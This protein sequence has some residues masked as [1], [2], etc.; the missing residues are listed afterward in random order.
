MILLG[1][2]PEGAAEEESGPSSGAA[3]GTVG[4]EKHEAIVNDLK[5]QLKKSQEA[6][7]EL[8]LLLDMYKTAP[9]E[10]RDKVELMAAEKR[11]KADLADLKAQLAK[12]QVG[13]SSNMF[14]KTQCI[15]LNFM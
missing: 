9:K 15:C 2:K 7:K 6:Q 10:Q 12:L 13:L 1:D 8:K 14:R 4:S 3:G 11:L 5:T